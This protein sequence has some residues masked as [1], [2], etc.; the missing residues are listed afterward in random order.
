M[1]KRILTAA[2]LAVVLGAVPA[3]AQ[4]TDLP[5]IHWEVVPG[6]LH[7]HGTELAL[8]TGCQLVGRANWNPDPLSGPRNSVI[9][10][11]LKIRPKGTLPGNEFWGSRKGGQPIGSGQKCDLS[12]G[13]DT[14]TWVLTGL[15]NAGR[16]L[17][18]AALADWRIIVRYHN[19][20]R[21]PPHHMIG[22]ANGQ[23]YEISD[24]SFRDHINNYAVSPA[25]ATEEWYE[26]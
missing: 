8:T 1:T 21:W 20:S 19:P 13:L 6:A 14:V 18:P 5:A 15:A 9:N 3:S 7:W 24:S 16:S 26:R 17:T 25:A 11:H 23:L 12:K 10:L 4:S 2:V 22:L